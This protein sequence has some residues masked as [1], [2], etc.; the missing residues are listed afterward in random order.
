MIEYHKASEFDKTF[1]NLDEYPT[2]GYNK[3]VLIWHIKERTDMINQGSDNLIQLE[4]AVP[5]NGWYGNPIPNDDYPRD[6]NRPPAWNG[7]YSGDFNY[8]DDNIVDL[9]S[10]PRIPKYHYQFRYLQD[11]GRHIWETTVT[12]EVNDYSWDPTDQYR[13]F[14]NQSLRSDF[15]TDEAIKGV[16]TN[17]ITDA[18]RPSTKEWGRLVN[19]NPVAEKTHIAITNI[20]RQAGYMALK[21]YYNYWE[22]NITENSTMSGNVIIGNNLTVASGVTLTIQPGTNLIFSNGTSLIVNGT[23]NAIGTP[24]NKITFDR[25]GTTGTW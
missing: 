19:G 21:V 3:G 24:S 18:T 9:V 8:L 22:G 2:Y 11:G 23:L 20:T 7:I 14:R 15:F 4:T 5:Y 12:P 6:Y 16:V 1:E 10:T 13:F 17:R 25:N